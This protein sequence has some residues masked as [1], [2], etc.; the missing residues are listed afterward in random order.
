[1]TQRFDTPCGLYCGACGALQATQNG[2]VEAVAK[3]WGMKPEDIVC[4]G[5][6]SETTAVFCNSCKFRDCVNEKGVDY[7]YQC[8]EYPCHDLKTF[9]NDQM[10]HHSVVLKNSDRMKEIGVEA[11]LCEQ[12]TR[13]SCSQCGSMFMWYDEKCPNCD[14]AVR[15]ANHEHRELEGTP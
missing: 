14:T 5:C 12:K 13:W 8:K 2:T 4:N 11:W 6:L 9:R 10:P 7:C 15:N 1:M 3:G